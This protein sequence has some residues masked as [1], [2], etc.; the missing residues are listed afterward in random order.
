MG[1]ENIRYKTVLVQFFVR[2]FQDKII[3][4]KKASVGGRTLNMNRCE[5]PHRTLAAVVRTQ[6]V[7]P[8]REQRFLVVQY[9]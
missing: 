6:S 8:I 3:S 7:V 4:G 5:G 9:L 2:R 1:L